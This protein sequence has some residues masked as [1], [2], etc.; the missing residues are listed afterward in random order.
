[1]DGRKVYDV[2]KE[3]IG[4]IDPVGES[5]TDAK[6]LYNI[7]ELIDLTDRLIADICLATRNTTGNE[8][9]VWNVGEHARKYL[10]DLAEELSSEWLK[11]AE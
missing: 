4:S 8:Y 5:Y 9:T 3:L 6:V 2:V 11:T 7:K 10:I 1:M